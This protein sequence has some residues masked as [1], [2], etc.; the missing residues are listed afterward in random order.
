MIYILT[1]IVAV[2]FGVLSYIS[3]NTEVIAKNSGYF[4]VALTMFAAA[5]LLRL[6]RGIPNIKWEGLPEEKTA[7]LLTDLVLVSRDYLVLF[8]LIIFGFSIL[9]FILILPDIFATKHDT[10]LPWA[11]SGFGGLFG[12]IIARM[13]HIAWRDYDI[14]KLQKVVILYSIS[15]ERKEIETASAERKLENM[16]ENRITQK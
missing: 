10:I 1:I 11:N 7:E 8:C 3:P 5:V 15:A 9:F 4:L 13:L 2:G 16:Q 14:V 12:L 6:N